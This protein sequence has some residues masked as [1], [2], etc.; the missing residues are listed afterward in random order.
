MATASPENPENYRVLAR[1]FRPQSFDQIVGQDA[2]LE[3]VKSA[4]ATGRV[5]HALLFAGSRGVGKTTMARVLARCLNCVEGVSAEP[6]G[7]CSMCTT[8][9]E[10][11]NGDVHEIDAASHNLVDDIRELRDRVGFASMGGR[12]KVY[13]LDEVHMLTRSAFNAFLKT[14]EE[15]PRGVIFILATTELQK[16]PETIRS[17][18]Q[19]LLFQRVDEDAIAKRLAAIATD[20]GLSIPEEV[21]QDLARSAR[22]GMRDA[23][24][25]LERILPVAQKMGKEFGVEDC[26]RLLRRTDQSRVIEVVAALLGGEA[27]PAMHFVSELVSNGVDEREILGQ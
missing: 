15:P 19:V 10:G 8:I 27:A 12:Y 2:I 18:C 25:A 16:V 26:R 3:T 6:C 20:E 14:L 1:R 7:K 22:G 13:I 17:R 23:E 21:L 5:P 9:L 11:S 24:T 4:L